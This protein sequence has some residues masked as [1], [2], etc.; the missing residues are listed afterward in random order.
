[1]DNIFVFVK[2]KKLNKMYRIKYRYINQVKFK[3]HLCDVLSAHTFHARCK[4]LRARYTHAYKY[5]CIFSGLRT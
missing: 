4:S 2:E 1:M 3:N 5:A